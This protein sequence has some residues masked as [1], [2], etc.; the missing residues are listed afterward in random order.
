MT[1]SPVLQVVVNTALAFRSEQ[2]QDGVRHVV[3]EAGDRF[4]SAARRNLKHGDVSGGIA[5]RH[6]QVKLTENSPGVGYQGHH[7]N[8]TPNE[9]SLLPCIVLFLQRS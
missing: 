2:S 4:P 3:K 5:G 9:R 6:S 1:Y 7:R 8:K